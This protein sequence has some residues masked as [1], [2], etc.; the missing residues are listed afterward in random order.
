MDC[1]VPDFPVHHHLLEFAQ[2]DVHWVSDAIQPSHS[3]L[4]LS[5][6]TLNLSLESFL[7]SQLSASGGQSIG[8]SALAS[9]L[10]MNIQGW[11]SLGL[12]G[13]ISLLSKGLSRIFSSTFEST[14][15]SALSLLYNPHLY[16][17]TGKNV[18]L[19]IWTFAGKVKFL[20]L[21]ALS[22][23][24]IAFPPRSKHLLIS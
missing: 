17:T 6:S 7:M 14:I 21:N 16:M 22:G 19:T 5:P 24:V 20:L 8:A 18:T 4:P 15:F 3:L 23:F 1:S 13:L 12:T 11:F 2:T 10:T 9:V